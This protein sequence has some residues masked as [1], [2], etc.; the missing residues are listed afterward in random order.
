MSEQAPMCACPCH[1]GKGTP[2]E[3]YSWIWDDDRDIRHE[4]WI[5]CKCENP[6]PLICRHEIHAG[7][8]R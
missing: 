2:G 7:A 3:G 8:V 6:D 5:D 1:H 4:D